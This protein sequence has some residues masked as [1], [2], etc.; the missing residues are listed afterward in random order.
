MSDSAETAAILKQAAEWRD[1]GAGKVAVA[2]VI[3]SWN[4]A[5]RPPGSRM[6]IRED[7]HA[8]G[9]VSGGCVENE[10]IF[11]A[12]ESLQ[13]GSPKRLSFGVAD[14]TAWRAGLTCGGSLEVLVL[15]LPSA[16]SKSGGAIAE[17]CA[18]IFARKSGALQTNM[19][20]GEMQFDSAADDSES[21]EI[22]GDIFR[23]HFAPQK[24]AAI[25]GAV[26]IAQ[27]LAPLLSACGFA[28]RVI[29]PRRAWASA[30]RFPNVQLDSR[31]PEEALAEMS[32]DFRTAVIAISHDPKIDDPALR[33]ALRANAGYVGALGSRRT[34]EKRLQRLTESGLHSEMLARIHS[35]IGADI[36]A[37]TAAEIAIS[38]AAEMISF[39]RRNT[40]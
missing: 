37:K 3:K 28:A 12:R 2:T 6:L 29:D 4:S 8:A 10:V 32:P 40:Q 15:P 9:S 11:A 34:H 18:A 26:H 14:E 23:E 36:G 16:D 22:R 35:P 7:G 17:L 5:P 24:R 25:V 33:S 39:Y 1:N 13:D 31:W 20:T 30:E 27:E 38:I 19:R 21:D